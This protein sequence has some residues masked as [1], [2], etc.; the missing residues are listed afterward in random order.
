MPNTDPA[1]GHVQIDHD[2]TF[3]DFKYEKEVH[4]QPCVRVSIYFKKKKGVSFEHFTQHWAHV[5]ADM[6]LASKKFGLFKVQRYT[7]HHQLPGMKEGLAR[8]GMNTMEFDG[9][10]TLW[11]KKWED[12]E[13]FFTSPEY[14]TNLTDD[15]KQFMDVEGGLSV[16]AGH[17]VIVLGKG[18]PDVDDQ[19]GLT[20]GSH[21]EIA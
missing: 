7:Q 6:T 8:M 15:C 9:C 12:F 16:F 21:V 20:K 14:E 13:N 10:S 5:H 2:F 11:F 4:Y 17:D 1:Q 18:I 19:N 3:D